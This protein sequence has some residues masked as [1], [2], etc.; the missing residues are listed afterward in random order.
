MNAHRFHDSFRT[1]RCFRTLLVVVLAIVCTTV[2]SAQTAPVRRIGMFIGA[3]DGGRSRV[4]LR[5]AAEDARRM[6]QVMNELGSIAPADTYYLAD[7]EVDQVRSDLRRLTERVESIAPAA[8]RVEFVFYYSGHSD[9]QGL[10]IGDSRLPY[11]ELRE[12]IQGVGADV[13][14]AIVD[15]CESGAFTRLKGGDRVQPFLTD[16][17]ADM[18]G[19]A[20]LTS[21]SDS[22]AS[23]E[24]DR[25]QASFFTHFV[26]S[27][28]RGAADTTQS[29]RV[30]LNELYHYAFRETLAMTSSTTA[31]PQHPSYDIQLTGTGDIVLTDISRPEGALRFASGLSGRV[32]IRSAAGNIISEFHTSGSSARILAVPPGSYEIII[33]E[34]NTSLRGDFQVARHGT[35]EVALRDLVPMRREITRLRGSGEEAGGFRFA[36]GVFPPLEWEWSIGELHPQDINLG[37]SAVSSRVRNTA[38]FNLSGI[39][40]SLSGNNTGLQISGVAATIAGN[41]H[42]MAVSGIFQDIGG[43]SLGIS[44]S[45]LYSVI[46]GTSVGLQASGIYTQSARTIGV[47]AAPFNRSDKVTGGQIGLFNQA[48]T[49]YGTQI[50]L[51]NV[52]DDVYG[53]PIGLINIIHNGINDV[54]IWFEDDEL[55]KLGVRN[56]TRHVYSLFFLD[57]IGKIPGANWII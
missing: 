34:Q 21:S 7:P 30:T 23:Q 48:G 37:L 2:A 33:S 19:F 40:S 5:W 56:G 6:A 29:G 20:F 26:V 45:G 18:T 10:L 52:A 43:N 42:G 31:G 15:G 3:N 36:A 38:G 17:S 25:I 12:L 32:L 47:Q 8:R 39:H 35:T 9:D 28:L 4:T 22:E 55:I 24:S 41:S 49:V 50:G 57:W 44:V 13:T 16:E 14:V 11:R 53:V 27:G 54:T 1:F 46:A 51:V